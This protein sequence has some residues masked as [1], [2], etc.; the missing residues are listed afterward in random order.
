MTISDLSQI[1]GRRYP[2]RRRTQNLAGA[3]RVAM[4]S[5]GAHNIKEMQLVE[6]IIA[7]DIKSEGKVYQKAQKLGMGK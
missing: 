4:G 3:L 1:E 6:I 5:L 2:A 7:P